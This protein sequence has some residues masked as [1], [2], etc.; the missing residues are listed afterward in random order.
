MGFLARTVLAE[1]TPLDG[2]EWTRVLKTRRGFEMN[3]GG[4][5]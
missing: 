4:D 1:R 5:R 2:Q 3:L